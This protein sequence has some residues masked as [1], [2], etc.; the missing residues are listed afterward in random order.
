MKYTVILLLASCGADAVRV[1]PTLALT[2]I[3]AA[4]V[5]VDGA[6]RDVTETRLDAAELLFAVRQAHPEI[7][8]ARQTAP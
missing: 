7:A 6:Q 2:P 1:Q 5:E 8:T 4:Y 3:D